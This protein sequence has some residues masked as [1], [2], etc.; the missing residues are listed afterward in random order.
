M[1]AE[2]ELYESFLEIAN[3]MGYRPV[4]VRTLDIGCDKPCPTSG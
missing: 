3:I 1:P 4:I 2:E